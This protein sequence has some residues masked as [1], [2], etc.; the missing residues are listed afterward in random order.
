MDISDGSISSL[1]SKGCS[2]QEH[3]S[4]ASS[5]ISS[6][7]T[8]PKESSSNFVSCAKTC[9][10]D[11]K[12]LAYVLNKQVYVE[13][14]NR[15]VYRTSSNSK[16]ITNGVPSYIVQEEL[17]RFNGIWWSPTH[18]RLLYEHVNEEMVDNAHFGINGESPTAPMK[19]PR[20]GTKN[21]VSTLR[22]VIFEDNKVHD[23]ALKP[24][25]LQKHCP[26]FEYITRAGFFSDGTS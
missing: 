6:P 16:H 17:E 1:G 21:A 15:V 4:S 8:P 22:M 9:P 19:Y 5:S 13:K 12:L 23:V 26:N 20:A 24:G 7:P 14:D 18:R 25:L 3:T 2:I 11:D 10:C